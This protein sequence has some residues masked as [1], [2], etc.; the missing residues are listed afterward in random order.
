MS[1]APG[2]NVGPRF[3]LFERP[4]IRFVGVAARAGVRDTEL[5]GKLWRNEAEGVAA[6]VVIAESLC[7]FG[8]VAGG[9]LASGAGFGV[10]CVL[11]YGSVQTGGVV[12]V[13]APE[14]EAIAFDRE[15]R[16]VLVTV[17]LVAIK[18]AKPAMVHDAFREVVA[19]HSVLVR[20][21][22]LPEV[23]I[24]RAELRVLQVP[25][26]GEPIA[27]E[28][29]DW[30]IDVLSVDGNMDGPS[31]AVALDADIIAANKVERLRIDNVSQGRVCNMLT[32]GAMT[33]FTAHIPLSRLPRAEVV[34]HGV[35][36]VAGWTGGAMLVFLRV[37]LCPPVG[38]VGH[39]V[40]EP[41]SMF[42]IPLRGQRVV[43][44]A[45]LREIALL[46]TAAINKGDLAEIE[47]AC[48]IGIREIAKHRIRMDLRIAHHIS[49]A[50]L[51]PSVVFLP[52]TAAARL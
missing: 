47:G 24:L 1:D 28:K 25:D 11:A 18:A 29:A 4:V 39:M 34:V 43:G 10:V 31:L 27:W 52:V 19:L 7:D 42:D 36:A 6:Y 23:E 30:P 15:I 32:A 49:H 21:C 50:C 20:R 17:H 44:V 37:E 3:Q 51:L 8:H 22:I 2:G 35:A 12:A 40:R 45:A 33:L 48:G 46:P 5:K 16:S 9:A 26:V 14:A 38:A 41:F 13:V